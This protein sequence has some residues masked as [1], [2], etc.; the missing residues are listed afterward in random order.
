[1]ADTQQESSQSQ[2]PADDIQVCCA[3]G[4]CV[5]HTNLKKCGDCGLVAY[6]SR[7]HQVEHYKDGH[8]LIC[9]GRE[10][11]INIYLSVP[12]SFTFIYPVLILHHTV[13]YFLGTPLTFQQCFEKA[14]SY[15]TEKKWNAALMYYSAMLE[16]TERSLGILHDQD[17]NCL[18][19]MALCYR[20][21]NK[22]DAAIQCLQRCLVI[23]EIHNDGSDVKNKALANL[24]G[25]IAE[26]YILNNQPE[27]AKQCLI[28]TVEE[29]KTT[30]GDDSF[31]IGKALCTLAVCYDKLDEIA[32]AEKVL[33]QACAITKYV[34]TTTSNDEI[35][36]AS[37][38]FYNLGLIY[39]KQNRSKEALIQ[40]E[41][42][43]QM[44]LNAKVPVEHEDMVTL[45]Q[46]L[47]QVRALVIA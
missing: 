46:K 24:L 31:E 21:Q 22:M 8:K 12:L 43:Y 25:K 37:N 27:L 44:R 26:Y 5:G 41:K 15:F 33:V 7:E 36:L 42:A 35:A 6:C 23:R 45:T 10:K 40:Y 32:E 14:S 1:M 13:I 28:K 39:S 30:F 47:E 9:P 2:T 16:L 20:H 3:L 38:A 34:D 19:V 11:G 17:A 18:D 4:R 29:I